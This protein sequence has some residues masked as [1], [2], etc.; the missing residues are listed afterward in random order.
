MMQMNM[1]I[2]EKACNR[3]VSL[4]LLEPVA[5]VAEREGHMKMSSISLMASM[6]HQ[7]I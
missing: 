1:L 5:Q 4:F 6:I 7:L 2:L 3:S